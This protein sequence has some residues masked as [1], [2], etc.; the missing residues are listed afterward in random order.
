MRPPPRSPPDTVLSVILVAVAT[1][2]FAAPRRAPAT[3]LGVIALATAIL[4][5]L[6]RSPLSMDVTLAVT[7]YTVA[8]HRAA[9]FG[10]PE[11]FADLRG[12]G[13]GESV[14]ILKTAAGA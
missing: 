2:P 3:V 9:F 13:C 4:S 10:R 14:G 1:L 6:G 12:T 8:T 11:G 7:P 5:G